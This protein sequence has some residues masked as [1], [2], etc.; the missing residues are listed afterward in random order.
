MLLHDGNMYPSL[1]LAH[2]V[3]LQ[4]EY[5]NIKILLDVLKYERYSW[6]VIGDFKIVTF[7]IGL[8]YSFTN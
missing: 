8:Q 5:S 3:Q 2:L 6:K 4:E 7:W 1:S